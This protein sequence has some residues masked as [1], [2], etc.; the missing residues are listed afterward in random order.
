MRTLSIALVLALAAPALADDA[1]T[2]TYDV[3]YEQSASTCSPDPLT[4]KT[5]SVTIAIKKGALNVSFDPA[6]ALVGKPAKDGTINAKTLKLIGTSVGGLSARY[7][8]VGRV[9]AG[10]LTAALTAQYIRQDTNRP[11]CAQTW[12]LTGAKKR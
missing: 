12:N 7:T 2:G 5:G 6:Y 11:Y 10:A 8:L 3:T 4:L 1:V 9:A